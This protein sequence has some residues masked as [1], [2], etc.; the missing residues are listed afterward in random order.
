MKLATFITF[1]EFQLII[2]AALLAFIAV[3][4]SLPADDLQTAEQFYGRGLYRPYYRGFHPYGGY[5]YR[6]FGRRFGYYG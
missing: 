1:F 2:L 5:G 3:A 4:M 6:G